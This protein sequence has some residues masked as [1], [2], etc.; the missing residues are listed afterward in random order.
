MAKGSFSKIDYSLRPNKN[1]ERKLIADLLVALEPSLKIHN[2]TY[3]GMG[4]L[5][6]VDFQ[7][8]HKRLGISSMISMESK[9][10]DRAKFNQPYD[11]I[12]VLDG[13][14]SDLLPDL[15]KTQREQRKNSLIWLDHDGSWESS[16]LTDLG[17]VCDYA[18]DGDIF[19]IT[20]NCSLPSPPPEAE[21]ITPED[22]SSRRKALAKVIGE[23]LA[24][25]PTVSELTRMGF[26]PAAAR[27]LTSA[28]KH[29]LSVSGE[30]L[31]YFPLFNFS[32][33]DGA[34]MVTVG[35]VIGTEERF[36]AIK[37]IVEQK[38]FELNYCQ[39]P[40]QRVIAVPV[41]TPREK[42]GLDRLLPIHT[43]L[44]QATVHTSLAFTLSSEELDAYSS[45]YKYYPVFNELV[46]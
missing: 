45:F 41:L 12:N 26:P 31:A 7:I 17:I 36:Q 13:I 20:V 27:I 15:L 30:G 10:V 37:N 6:F 4:S 38:R 28:I 19:L 8:F 11:C 21:K 42:S 5:W 33:S 34:P 39:E 23:D 2:Y 16:A 29:R 25:I 44:D 24:L 3:L 18:Q 40:G 35:G 14:T 32:Y 9:A 46:N 43:S 1:V 22:P